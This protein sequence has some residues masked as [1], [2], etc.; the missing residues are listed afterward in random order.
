LGAR[1]S[2][3]TTL[4]LLFFSSES[5]LALDWEV[6]RNFRYFLYPSDVAVQRVARDLYVVEQ[7]SSP[8]RSSSRI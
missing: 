7:G 3:F 8:T 6:E 4:V 5:A 2:L 1:C